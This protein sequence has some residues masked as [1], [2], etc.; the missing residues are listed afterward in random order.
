L[1]LVAAALEQGG[2]V[3][4]DGGG[5]AVEAGLGDPD[6]LDPDYLQLLL[7]EVV[8]LEGSPG[9]VRLEEIEFDREAQLRPVRVELLPSDV[10]VHRG[11]R[12]AGGDDEVAEAPLEARAGEGRVR[13]V[14]R[15]GL[16]KAPAP[17][18]AAGAVEEGFDG[19]DIQQVPFFSPLEMTVQLVRPSAN[20]QVHERARHPR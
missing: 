10:E 19:C 20:R 1:E 3:A 12:E 11:R 13:L 5:F 2:E 18:V 6:H 16:A 4:N 15:E 17:A 14:E 9:T 8:A 7:A